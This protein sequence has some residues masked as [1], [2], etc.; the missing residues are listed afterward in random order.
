M[1]KLPLSVFL[2]CWYREAP[3]AGFRDISLLKH[4]NVGPTTSYPEVNQLKGCLDT[5]TL[6]L[7]FHAGANI[8]TEVREVGEPIL[9]D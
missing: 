3:K 4:F 5:W 8:T 7:V 1:D 2:T 9:N 6:L